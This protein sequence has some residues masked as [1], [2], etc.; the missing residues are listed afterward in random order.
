MI[1]RHQNVWRRDERRA[2]AG[3]NRR[4]IGVTREEWLF[5]L[6]D[7][8][9]LP[10]GDER[11]AVHPVAQVEPRGAFRIVVDDALAV[12]GGGTKRSVFEVDDD[13]VLVVEV[14]RR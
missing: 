14:H 7:D 12:R 13:H 9:A 4:G 5:E 2:A 6:D 10:A 11:F 3:M 8:R 1:V